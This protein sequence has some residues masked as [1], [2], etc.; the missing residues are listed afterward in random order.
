MFPD[1][2]PSST[3]HLVMLIT[4][5][6][7]YYRFRVKDFGICS[8]IKIQPQRTIYQI[9]KNC[10]YNDEMSTPKDN[11]YIDE[12]IQIIYINIFIYIF[13]TKD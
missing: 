1:K 2:N 5:I 6:L 9:S 10:F 12:T 7:Q 13:E 8:Q 4:T 3:Y 11:I